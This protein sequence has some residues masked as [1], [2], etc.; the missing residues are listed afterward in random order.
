MESSAFRQRSNIVRNQKLLIRYFWN[1]NQEG[2]SFSYGTL[3]L[4][5]PV[6]SIRKSMYQ[7]K[8]ETIARIFPAGIATEKSVKDPVNTFCRNS[9]SGIFYDKRNH[10]PLAKIS[11]DNAKKDLK[12]KDLEKQKKKRRKK[13]KMVF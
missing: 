13:D 6:V 9:A 11:L 5:G 10:K 3:T 2:S 12:I 4:N 1:F 7:R 8:P